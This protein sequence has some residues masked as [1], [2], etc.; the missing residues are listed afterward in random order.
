MVGVVGNGRDGITNF[1][2]KFFDTALEGGGVFGVK[3]LN[4]VDIQNLHFTYPLKKRYFNISYYLQS[5]HNN[6]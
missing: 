5:S 4:R 3:F 1:F 2:F 6:N